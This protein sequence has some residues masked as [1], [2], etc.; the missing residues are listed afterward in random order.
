MRWACILLPQLAL[1]TVLRQ[2]VDPAA[3]LALVSGPVQRRVLHAVNAT[4]RE[5][6]LR[7]GMALTTAQLLSS[8]V[9]LLAYDPKAEAQARD[10]LA[11][12]PALQ[13][14]FDELDA[15]LVDLFKDRKQFKSRLFLETPCTSFC[16]SLHSLTFGI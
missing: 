16:L 14:E 4:A 3:P 7:R 15:E 10:M 2:Q 12:D 11:A 5:T 13:K 8:E 9:H 6:G 1:D